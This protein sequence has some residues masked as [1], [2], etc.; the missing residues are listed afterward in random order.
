MVFWDILEK[1]LSC[2]VIMWKE[3]SI[4][5][6]ETMSATID[7]HDNNDNDNS[8]NKEIYYVPTIFQALC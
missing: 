1:C 8:S 6:Q 7:V 3:Y 4:E 5:H 2:S